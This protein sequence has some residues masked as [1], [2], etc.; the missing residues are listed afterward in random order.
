MK[1]EKDLHGFRLE[2]SGPD[3]AFLYLPAASRK[4]ELR[5]TKSFDVT[6]FI[7]GYEG[8]DILFDFDE[9]GVLV[10]IEILE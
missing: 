3:A 10:R 7:E 9:D 4:K 6:D 1:K 2:V 8:P 5:V